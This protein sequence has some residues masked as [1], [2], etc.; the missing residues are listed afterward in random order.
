MDR[1]SQRLH[2][3][4]ARDSQSQLADHLPGVRRYQ[5]RPDDLAGPFPGVDRG[6]QRELSRRRGAMP[7]AADPAVVFFSRFVL[8]EVAVRC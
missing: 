2:R 3:Q 4:L 6:S 8:L 1:L 5:C 7:L